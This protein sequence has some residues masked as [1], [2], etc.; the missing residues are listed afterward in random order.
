MPR[1]LNQNL[2]WARRHTKP[3]QPRRK[4]RSYSII[5]VRSGH[6]ALRR[7]RGIELRK[8]IAYERLSNHQFDPLQNLLSS[9]ELDA[10]LESEGEE[11][12]KNIDWHHTVQTSQDPGMADVPEHIQP[13]RYTEHLEEH[14]GD[15]GKVP[16]AGLRGDVTTPEQPIYDPNAPEVQARRYNPY[17]PTGDEGLEQEGLSEAPPRKP[18][19]FRNLRK[20]PKQVRNY[21]DWAVRSPEG[22][23]FRRHKASGKWVLF[24]S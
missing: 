17:E 18:R 11:L 19:N 6:A 15:P 1:P 21:Y 23:V 2:R 12:P 8:R 24:Q 13:V 10:F 5:A 4:A 16:T 22:D 7:N 3:R 14:L 9:D 20:V